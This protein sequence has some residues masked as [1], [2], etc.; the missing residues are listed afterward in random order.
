MNVVVHDAVPPAPAEARHVSLPELY[1]IADV[2]VLHCP[3]TP[4]TA[5]MIDRAALDQM[6]D[7]VILINNARGA[8]VV[9]ADLAEALNSGK[10]RAAGL[11][12][13]AVEPIRDESPLLTAKNCVITPH[14][15]WA[16]RE[17]RDRLMG[18]AA[19]NLRQFLAGTPVNVVNP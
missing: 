9:E 19:D 3:T 8:L 15:S 5:G 1:R 16:S 12:V 6:K 13:V 11:D 14:M 4:A 17:A 7:G 18:I 10:V 2:V